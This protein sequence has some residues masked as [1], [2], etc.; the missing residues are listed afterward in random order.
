M[1]D[2]HDLQHAGDANDEGHSTGWLD[3]AFATQRQPAI[4][5]AQPPLASV[6]DARHRLITHRH[7]RRASHE[8]V[9]VSAAVHRL[10]GGATV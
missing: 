6:R 5:R 10:H 9:D 1:E 4:L 8:A 2:Q 3:L 7:Q